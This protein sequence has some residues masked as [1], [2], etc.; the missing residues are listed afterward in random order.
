MFRLS[1]WPIAFVLLLSGFRPAAAGPDLT[2]S[3]AF[4]KEPFIHVVLQNQGDE[5]A[6]P[7]ARVRAKVWI[8][9]EKSFVIELKAPNR[10]VKPFEIVNCKPYS[11][12]SE[13]IDP[14]YLMA[15]ELKLDPKK[16]I[17]DDRRQNNYLHFQN[18]G[19]KGRFYKKPRPKYKPYTGLPDLV[20]TELEFEDG[21]VKATVKNV[22]EG[23][24]GTYFTVLFEFNNGQFTNGLYP[25][26]E[27]GEVKSIGVGVR[28][29]RGMIGGSTVRVK[30]QVDYKDRVRELREDNNRYSALVKFGARHQ[31]REKPKRNCKAHMNYVGYHGVDLVYS[32]AVL[33]EKK[34]EFRLVMLP[35][36]PKPEDISDLVENRLVS[37]AWR[38]T[39]GNAQSSTRG[40]TFK[41][42]YKGELRQE[43]LQKRKTMNL[44]YDRDNS[45]G[46]K[47][48]T[49]SGT[50]AVKPRGPIFGSYKPGQSFIRWSANEE[51]HR[52]GATWAAGGKLEVKTQIY[53]FVGKG[54]APIYVRPA[55]SK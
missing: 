52:R 8:G 3:N 51:W 24:T 17:P 9:R 55:S 42:P 30:A 43:H 22:G 1:L 12:R 21:E 25:I 31:N 6:P 49:T 38:H 45:S 7:G 13:L 36:I 29:S 4:Y 10:P 41:V 37:T 35:F 50:I 5:V 28:K 34:K 16:L 2:I 44:S 14:P 47:A 40:V 15:A 46:G 20:I 39:S 23:T 11:L 48:S 26:P 18:Y 54:K 27:K 33:D 32:L 53:R 19:G